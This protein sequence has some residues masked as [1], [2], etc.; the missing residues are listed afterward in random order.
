MFVSGVVIHLT[1][2]GVVILVNV[3]EIAPPAARIPMNVTSVFVICKIEFWRSY[4][5]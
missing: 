1:V 5:R 4:Y 2:S 3:I